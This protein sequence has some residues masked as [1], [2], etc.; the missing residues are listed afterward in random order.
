MY[1]SNILFLGVKNMKK[2]INNSELFLGNLKMQEFFYNNRY[3]ILIPFLIAVIVNSIDIF[4]IKFGVDSE[5]YAQTTTYIYN[6]QSRYGSAILYHLFP[7]ARYHIISQIIGILSLIFAAL[8]TISR[9]NIPNNAKFVFVLLFVLYPNYIFLQYF[10]FQFAYNCIGLLLVVMAYRLIEKNYFIYYIIAILFLFIGI[11]SYQSNLAIF[12]T[13]MMIN[14]IL[15]YLNDK[16][17]KKAYITIFKTVAILIIPLIIY[18]VINKLLSENLINSHHGNFINSYTTIHKLITPIYRVLASVKQYDISANIIAFICMIVFFPII[19]Y[20]FLHNKERISFFILILFFLLAIFSLNISLNNML[21]FRSNI[22]HAFFSAFVFL[23][24]LSFL[25][26]NILKYLF[27]LCIITISI[28]QSYNI[29]KYEMTYYMQYNEDARRAE[30]I[31]NEIYKKFP[32]V[33]NGKYN[34]AYYGKLNNNNS[35]PLF[36]PNDLFGSSFFTWDNGNSERML[37]FMQLHGFSMNIKLKRI[38]PEL[39]QYIK[40][41]PIYPNPDCIGLYDNNTIVVRL[42]EEKGRYN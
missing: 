3:I 10:Y 30:Y 33:N 31:A 2:F 35:H 24:L 17:I 37:K 5:L 18:F 27:Y 9:H 12:L 6:N 7:F 41:L 26:S 40:T 1:N 28:Y 20:K 22:A 42:S 32:D 11:T 16:N 4:T 14:I 34:I 36:K 13:V 8:L 39:E 21:S 23:L 25:K 19:A 29:V 38:N 15:D